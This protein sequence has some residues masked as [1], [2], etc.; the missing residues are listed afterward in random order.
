M[1][2]E[3]PTA[4]ILRD[5]G[6]KNKRIEQIYVIANEDA[7]ELRVESGCPLNDQF[8]TMYIFD[9]LIHNTS[10]SRETMLYIG[11]EWRLLLLGPAAAF[12][13]RVDWPRYLRRENLTPNAE[14]R[15]RLEKL[16]LQRLSDTLGDVL[17]RSQIQSIIK[18]RDRLLR[19]AE[20]E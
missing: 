10:R 7:G 3:F 6:I 8:S 13:S 4:K 2:L 5:G 17:D 16:D 20:H 11:G 14:W 12:A 9:A 1:G 15:R 19:L 18:R